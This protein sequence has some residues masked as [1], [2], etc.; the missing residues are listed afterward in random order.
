MN[1]ENEIIKI[2]ELVS[3]DKVDL[4]I[5]KLITLSRL[6]DDKVIQNQIILNCSNYKRWHNDNLL[7][8]TNDSVG[9]NKAVLSILEFLDDIGNQIKNKEDKGESRNNKNIYQAN[10][11]E[12]VFDIA[13]RI[14]KSRVLKLLGYNLKGF[15]QKYR[16]ALTTALTNGCK[17]QIILVDVYKNETQKI[18]TEHARKPHLLIPECITGLEY[19]NDIIE[20]AKNKKI[21]GTIEIKLTT[22][23]PSCSIYIFKS[24]NNMAIASIHPPSFKQTLEGRMSLVFSEQENPSE[25]IYFQ[26]GFDTIWKEASQ[27]WDLKIPKI[28]H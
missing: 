13:D 6:T 27:T 5:E 19:I 1:I 25:F 4:A 12:K 7:S 22:W 3:L 28:A 8:L 24:E 10:D 21:E 26:N 9:R 16:E 17:I 14:I 2:K 23:I 15:L 11:V 18:M 20:R